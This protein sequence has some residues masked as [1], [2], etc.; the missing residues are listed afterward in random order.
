MKRLFSSSK[1]VITMMGILS[2]VLVSFGVSEE[3]ASEI[4]DLLM[5]LI[6]ALVVAYSAATAVEDGLTKRPGGK[7]G[8]FVT[9]SLLLSMVMLPS[10]ALIAGCGYDDR[11]RARHDTLTEWGADDSLKISE[12]TTHNRVTLMVESR[13]G[14]GVSV[15]LDEHGIPTIT[16]V[17]HLLY[18]RSSP[19]DVM[20]GHIKIAESF[21]RSW[22]NT[23]AEGGKIAK[24]AIP[25]ASGGGAST[26]QPSVPTSELSD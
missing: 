12:N 14:E 18:Q 10:V 3:Q 20:S 17:T 22:A 4:T 2:L 6:T 5:K 8:G 1:A 19:T 21:E 13:D 11:V 16:G 7:V 25:Y 9:K 24:F 15:T 23:V 26:T